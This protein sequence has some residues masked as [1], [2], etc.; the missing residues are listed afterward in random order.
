[1]RDTDGRG[2][3]VIL[4]IIGAK[5]LA[6]NVRA[7]ASRGRLMVIGLQ[8][9][10]RAELDLGALMDQRGTVSAAKLRTRTVA[11]KAAICA[12]VVEHVWPLVESGQVRPVIHERLG[13]DQVAGAHRLMEAG[14]HVGKVLLEVTS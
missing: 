4:D 2:A 5:Y 1:L 9:G 11:E 10:S 13:L 14:D 7:L 3:D 8:G 12:D 6:R